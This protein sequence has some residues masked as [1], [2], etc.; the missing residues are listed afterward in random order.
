VLVAERESATKL[1]QAVGI[2]W[3]LSP[4]ASADAQLAV[5]R[6]QGVI[7]L[8]VERMKDG[9]EGDVIENE[10]KTV[11]IAKN[12]DQSVH[13]RADCGGAVV[14]T[15]APSHNVLRTSTWC[16]KACADVMAR[17]RDIASG[18]NSSQ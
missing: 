8:T 13:V 6:D 16:G 1:I 5:R 14:G 3:I 2:S 12:Q 11:E 9:P 4:S 17:R 15:A 18:P 10:I 7:S